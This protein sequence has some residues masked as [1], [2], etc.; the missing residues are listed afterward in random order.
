[1]ATAPKIVTASA[2]AALDR[3]LEELCET[4]QLTATQFKDAE[5]HYHAVGEWLADPGSPIALYRPQIRPQGSVRLKTTVKPLRQNEHDLDLILWLDLPYGGFHEPKQVFELVSARLRE[6]EFFRKNME[7][8]KRCIRITYASEFHLDITP[9]RPNW[10]LGGNNLLVPDRKVHR[11][12]D[13]NPIDYA[14]EWFDRHAAMSRTVKA[15]RSIE[16]LPERESAQQKA[17]LRR[18]VQLLKRHRDIRFKDD[19]DTA[20]R[21]IVL[22][23]LAGLHYRGEELVSDALIAI[24]DGVI[25]RVESE[26]SGVIEV[27]NP[28]CPAEKFCE[29]WTANREA[30]LEFVDYLHNLRSKLRELLDAR[31]LENI[32]RGLN[33]LFGESLTKQAVAS[34]TR[35]FQKDREAGRIEF[36]KK[37]VGLSTATPS[38]VATRPVPGNTF[39]GN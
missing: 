24:L 10:I 8:Y 21:S 31:G 27:P 5:G 33:E 17:P 29:A 34:Y 36:S 1:M 19:P 38:V 23:T 7:H 4:V 11:W 13:S 18:A 20:P 39:H 37:S 15:A 26:P 6:N 9:A 25:D 32:S 22:T 16:S 3:L 14:D 30:Y 12:K 35:K 2:N 28:V